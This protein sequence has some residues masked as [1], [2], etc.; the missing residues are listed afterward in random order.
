MDDGR[1]M[2]EGKTAGIYSPLLI[3]NETNRM[4]GLETTMTVTSQ[5]GGDGV[6]VIIIFFESSGACVDRQ[7][8]RA[9]I[10]LERFF[11]YI[12]EISR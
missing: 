6:F 11:E 1:N 8:W 4:Q 9:N 2:R 7:E 3:T 12:V 5:D 10:K